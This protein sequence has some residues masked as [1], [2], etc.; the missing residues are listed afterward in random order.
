MN[1]HGVG[2][3]WAT[4]T[5]LLLGILFAPSAQAKSKNLAKD[6]EKQQGRAVGIYVVGRLSLKETSVSRITPV[7]DPRQP[8]LQLTDAVHGTLTVVD[9]ARPAQ[10][11]LIEQSL[12]PA[13][14]GHAYVQIRMGDAALLS[15]PE[16]DS[17]SH[18]WEQQSIT[19]VSFAD[20]SNPKMV[21]KFEGVTAVWN[22][23]ERGLIFLANTDGLWIL[24]V[25]SAADKRAE[26]QFD[27][28][29]RGAASGG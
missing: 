5:L 18:P 25:Y 8:M 9:V 13:E 17:S 7:S 14:V 6:K 28:M 21:Q 26:E 12:L 27:E 10:P 1:F 19:L 22:D 20:T 23:R 4:T 24:E 15:V 3:R 29:L 16:G 2:N 11:K